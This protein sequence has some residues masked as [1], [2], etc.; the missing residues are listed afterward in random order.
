METQT[1]AAGRRKFTPEWKWHIV[2]LATTS[3]RSV[4]VIAREYDVNS[5]QLFRWIREVERGSARWVRV[6]KGL[7]LSRQAEAPAAFLP[8]AVSSPSPSA[9]LPANTS[10]TVALASG[11]RVSV[12]N[13]TPQ[14]LTT[15]LSV[16]A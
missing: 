13:A 16:L 2:E 3:E 9:E 4:S 11:H 6:M 10:I 7:P 12:D 15:L 1:D 5:N 14:M 8:V